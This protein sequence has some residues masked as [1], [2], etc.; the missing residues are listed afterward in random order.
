M[1]SKNMFVSAAT[2]CLLLGVSGA[3]MAVPPIRD[4]T[5]PAGVVL[6]EAVR[7]L[8]VTGTCIVLGSVIL[9]NVTVS[10]SDGDDFVLRDTVVNGLVKVTGG[11]LIITRTDVV[12]SNLE[13][14]DT[15]ETV[16][17]DTLVR[18]G[19]MRFE[20]NAYVL[21]RSNTVNDGDI[22]CVNNA[23]ELAIQN[24]VPNGVETCFGQ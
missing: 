8:T 13:V 17:N 12:G 18:A 15:T 4:S 11:S 23:V 22:Q 2:A 3:A 6:N 5:C 10:N 14:K 1:K 7:N 21:I 20:D 19:N 24:I 9:G 16:V